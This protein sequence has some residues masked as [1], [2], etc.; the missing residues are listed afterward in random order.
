[1][2]RIITILFVLCISIMSV[3]PLAAQVGKPLGAPRHVL[4]AVGDV[5][6]CTGENAQPIV[7]ADMLAMLQRQSRTY[8][9]P[10]VNPE[11]A[12]RT[13]MPSL[14][15]PPVINVNYN[16]F[17]S[18]P[19]ARAAFQRAVDIWKTLI[20]SSQT[21]TINANWQ[22][23][24]D[25]VLGAA[26]PTSI[27][28]D[29]GQA[30][31]QTW[32]PVALAEA[33]TGRNLNN[34][35]AEITATFNSTFTRWYFGL[36]GA[37]PASR[38]DFVSVVLHELCHGLG[39]VGGAEAGNERGIILNDNFPTVFDR[40]VSVPQSGVQS[41]PII[42]FPDN[43]Q[44]LFQ[45][46]TG[47]NLVVNGLQARFY[48]Q[49]VRPRLYAP[50]PWDSGSSYSHWDERSY[51][52]GNRNALMTPAI[53]AAT[54]IHTPGLTTLGFFQDMGWTVV[55]PQNLAAP[56]SV[57][58]TGTPP[59]DFWTNETAASSSSSVGW[60]LTWD[61]NN[62]YLG[63][64][65]T[66][67][68]FTSDPTILYIDTTP[69]NDS[70]P[71][72]GS[73]TGFAFV[74]NAPRLPFRANAVISLAS[75]S[76]SLRLTNAQGAW[77]EAI[78]LTGRIVNGQNAIELSIPWSAFP[79]AQRPVSM[80]FTGFK[81]R[82]TAPSRVYAVIP[83]DG[84]PLNRDVFTDSVAFT[85]SYSVPT[86]SI[87]QGANI[88]PF[89]NGIFLSAPPR[90]FRLYQNYPNPFNPSTTIEFD[91]LITQ[92]ITLKIYDVLGRLVARPLDN[93]FVDPGRVS[94]VFDGGRLASGMYFYR[95]SAGK[96]SESRKMLLVK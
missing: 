32:Y 55:V 17:E 80:R 65:D 56:H 87:T 92:R 31:R 28:R 78:P 79:N 74:G 82:S 81:Q 21:I 16:G 36:D 39:Y 4:T 18:Q 23:L 40:F 20:T 48:N 85:N 73:P 15:T 37:P 69:E 68:R 70:L 42:D 91:N 54:A 51:T 6:V 46:L 77:G 75:N 11:L 45:Q 58:F 12:T 47:N 84:F 72:S 88:D 89:S 57:V 66:I 19:Q 14:Q 29:F 95:I 93:A 94:V 96:I 33:L 2:Q 76:A 71:S 43:S 63:I 9:P 53:A 62:L 90:T 5:A 50:T 52:T 22:P 1:M 60:F 10:M 83:A 34:T 67:N 44:E 41:R 27:Y 25:R 49:N 38:F 59:L 61:A 30:Q 7:T 13:S 8:K 35:D 24:R 64:N 3:S 86:V 26:G